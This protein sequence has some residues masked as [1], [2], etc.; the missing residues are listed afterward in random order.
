MATPKRADQ[1]RAIRE[2]LAAQGPANLLADLSK[3]GKRLHLRDVL[4]CLAETVTPQKL[5]RMIDEMVASGNPRLQQQAVGLILEIVL[6]DARQNGEPTEGELAALGDDQLEALLHKTIE[7]L[8]IAKV[9]DGKDASRGSVVGEP[10][11]GPAGSGSAAGEGGAN[12]EPGQAPEDAPA[13]EALPPHPVA[14]PLRAD[15]PPASVP[16]VASP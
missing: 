11:T 16:H 5:A 7:E 1:V 6:Q 2:E 14:E 13:G 9:N 15:P 4:A 3:H 8:K 12:G 10:E